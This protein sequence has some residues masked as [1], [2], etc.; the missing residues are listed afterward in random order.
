MPRRPSFRRDSDLQNEVRRVNKLVQNKQSRLRTTKGLEVQ[1]VDTVKYTEFNSRKE[2]NRYL[3][4]MTGFLDKR[5]DFRVQN[6]KGAELQY[7]EVQ[8]I[9]RTISRVNR[10]KKEQWDRVKDLPYLHKGQPTGLTVGQQ[11]DPEVGIG[12]PKYNDFKPIKFNPGRFRTEKE[13][14]DWA[15]EKKD[16]YSK[17][18]LTRRNEL[19]RDN[20]IKSMENNLGNASKELQEHIK[21]MPL[22]DFVDMYYT[23][24]NAHINFVYDKLAVKARVEELERIWIKEV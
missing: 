8:Q 4:E 9:E 2:I 11:A 13:F 1:D 10:Q 24:N 22:Q 21:N 20:Y 3:K 17:D 19:Y 7:S 16:V 18:W 6:E 14:R 5:A 15:N 23:E 12:D